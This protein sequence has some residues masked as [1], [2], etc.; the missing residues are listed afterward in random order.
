MSFKF[1]YVDFA[2]MTGNATPNTAAF[3]GVSVATLKKLDTKDAASIIITHHNQEKPVKNIL[4]FTTALLCLISF[5]CQADEP[6]ENRYICN[7]IRN[8]I[9]ANDEQARKALPPQTQDALKAEKRRL[10]ADANKYEC[11]LM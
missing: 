2:E 5:T 6:P 7:S 8:A 10:E 3:F 11:S 9:K 4:A 1:D